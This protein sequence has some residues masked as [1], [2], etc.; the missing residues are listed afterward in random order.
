MKITSINLTLDELR[1][2]LCQYVK[3][4]VGSVPKIITVKSYNRYVIHIETETKG[5]VET[6]EIKHRA[7]T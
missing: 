1:D 5:L 7:S 4:R 6:I 2:A 3:K